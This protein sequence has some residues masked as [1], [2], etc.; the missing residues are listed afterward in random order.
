MYGIKE[1]LV[2][3]QRIDIE[4]FADI[5][6]ICKDCG[7]SYRKIKGILDKEEIVEFGKN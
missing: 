6:K 4:D 5:A 7:I 3:V 1:V 2:A